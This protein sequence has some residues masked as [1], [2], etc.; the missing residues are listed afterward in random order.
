MPTITIGLPFY[1]QAAFLSAA[2]RS[3]VNQSFRDW[4]LLLIDDGST[5][6]SVAVACHWLT[7]PRIRL[8]CDKKRLG[9]SSRLNQIARLAKG[10]FLARMDADD[11]MAP[12]RLQSQLNY[13]L[14]NPETDLTASFAYI[15]DRQ[16]RIRGLRGLPVPPPRYDKLLAHCPIIHPTVMGKT[17]WFRLHPYN[18]V[19]QR[20]ED[21]ELWLRTLPET[22][23]GILD[24]PLLFYRD[25]PRKHHYITAMREYRD[26]LRQYRPVISLIAY[27]FYW[28]V[29]YLKQGPLF[30]LRQS[31]LTSRFFRNRYRPMSQAYQL[32]AEA[33]LYLAQK[34][35]YAD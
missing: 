29:S 10:R 23:I 16:T 33:Q 19:L 28:S 22:T 3:V 32:H 35:T 30:A 21:L 1:N 25:L 5:D 4:E 34:S 2:I 27:R 24:E 15:I 17:D 9:L 31:K 13:L 26:I 14:K 11:L 20:T 12:N 18:P 8:L 7:D 6:D